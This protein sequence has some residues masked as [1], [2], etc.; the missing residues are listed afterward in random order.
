MANSPSV[1]IRIPPETLK[2]IDR[3]AQKLYPSRRVGKHPNRSQLILHA[4]EQFLEEHESS[5]AD[6]LD[7]EQPGELEIKKAQDEE[8]D[9]TAV[10]VIQEIQ[11]Y[12]QYIKSPVREYI[13]WWFDYFSYMKQ[14]TDAWF[15]A[16]Q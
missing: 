15:S 1:S 16:K 3:L 11:H 12:P 4:I 8:F 5:F 14:F 13:Y 2:R 7:D 10:A 9:D 6:T